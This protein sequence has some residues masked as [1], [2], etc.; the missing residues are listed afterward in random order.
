MNFWVDLNHFFLLM[1]LEENWGV[2]EKV[3]HILEGIQLLGNIPT[4]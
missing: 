3:F 4:K 2:Q 1:Q